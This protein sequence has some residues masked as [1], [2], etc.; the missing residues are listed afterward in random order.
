MECCA[1][2]NAY[3]EGEEAD[4]EDDAE[5]LA[6]FWGGNLNSWGGPEHPD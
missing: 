4:D 1:D 3:E 6:C 5:T 2:R